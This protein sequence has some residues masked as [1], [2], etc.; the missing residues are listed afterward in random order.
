MKNIYC[1]I[2]GAYPKV[3]SLGNNNFMFKDLHIW[4]VGG[5]YV[6]WREMFCHFEVVRDV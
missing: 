1:K 2:W 6:G 5:S 3:V 4:R